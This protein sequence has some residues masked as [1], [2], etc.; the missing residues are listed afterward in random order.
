MPLG[1]PQGPSQSQ[2]QIAADSIVMIGDYPVRFNVAATTDNPDADG[3]ADIVQKFVDL[4][5]GSADFKMI[6]ASRS[7]T[8]SQPITPSS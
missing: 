7:Y 2:W 3:V 4:V 8:Y 6:S 5:A 1:P